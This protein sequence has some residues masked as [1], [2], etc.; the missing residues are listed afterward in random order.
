MSL[1]KRERAAGEECNAYLRKMVYGKK[2]RKPFPDFFQKVF[3]S[4]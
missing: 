2:F 3:R 1:G 4:T